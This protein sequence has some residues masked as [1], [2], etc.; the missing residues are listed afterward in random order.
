MRLIMRRLLLLWLD[1]L[2][3]RLLFSFLRLANGHFFRWMLKNVILNGELL[4]E[5]YI[6]LPPG[7]SHPPGFPHRV[8]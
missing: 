5:V 3:S 1:F 7:Y 8:F 4:E 2:L 6:K